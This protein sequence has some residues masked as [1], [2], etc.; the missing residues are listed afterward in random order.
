MEHAYDGQMS[1]PSSHSGSQHH[2]HSHYQHQLLMEAMCQLSDP[3]PTDNNNC[4]E[5][6][7]ANITFP[8]TSES[9]STLAVKARCSSITEVRT[10]L[11]WSLPTS[12]TVLT[13]QWLTVVNIKLTVDTRV[14][15]MTDT[16]VVLQQLQDVSLSPQTIF[17]CH[18]YFNR[19]FSILSTCS[20]HL[21]DYIT[22]I[23]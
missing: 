7:C 5:S 2:Q 10:R 3:L 15:G 8:L 1:I 12:G 14:T 6:K 22:E 11:V 16:L 17:I 21:W 18:K 23:T 9:R 4:D 20:K 13:R 19:I